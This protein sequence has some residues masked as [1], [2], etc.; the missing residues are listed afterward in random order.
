MI[1]VEVGSAFVRYIN[2]GTSIGAVNFPEV[3]LR[4][5]EA[6]Q[7]SARLLFVHH[8]VPGVLKVR[9]IE[10]VQKSRNGN[11]RII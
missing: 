3:D 11:Y 7:K 5:I 4:A 10:H 8:N 6:S 2:Y 9:E 1:G